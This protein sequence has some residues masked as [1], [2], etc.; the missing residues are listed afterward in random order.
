MVL[1]GRPQGQKAQQPRDTT[2]KKL[3]TNHGLIS[4]PAALC[5]AEETANLM[6]K[7][8]PFDNRLIRISQWR[9]IRSEKYELNSA[10]DTSLARAAAT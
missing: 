2:D 3:L 9:K 5:Q 1:N 6:R 7:E 8:P 4:L 10:S